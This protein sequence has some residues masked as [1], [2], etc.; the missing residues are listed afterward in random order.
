MISLIFFLFV[1]V[2]LFLSLFLLARRNTRP[3]GSSS[4]L[5]EARQALKTLQAGLLPL[6]LVKR[7]FAERDWE[8]VRAETPRSIHELFMAERKA[9]ALLW[10]TEVRSQIRSLQRFHR[11]AARHYARLNPRLEVELAMSFAA[12]TGAC[13]ALQ[14]LVYIAGPYAAPRMVSV[15]ANVAARACEISQ[16]SLSFLDTARLGALGGQ[17][18]DAATL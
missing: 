2:L 8:Y 14:A 12:L 17:P 6:D 5:V 7:V 11:G 18:T 4:A 10:L 13:M 3:E 9:I 1:G 15:V 16:Q